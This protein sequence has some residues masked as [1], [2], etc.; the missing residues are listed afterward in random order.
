[1]IHLDQSR[2]ARRLADEEVYLARRLG[3][4]RALGIALRAAGL[5]RGGP[6]GVALLEEA[7]TVLARSSARLEQ[8]RALADYGAA[9]RRANRRTESREP[10]RRALDLAVQCGAAPLADRA[11]Q[12]LAAAGV[13]PRR[14][15]SGVDALTPS[16]LRV[17]RMAAD[18]M[19]NRAIAKA[20][21]VTIKTVEVHLS[22]AYR[23]LDIASRTALAAALN[24]R[25]TGE[26]DM[27]D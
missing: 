10:L 15:A 6:A 24:H 22:S 14:A 21:F 17:V 26:R 1:L 20:L 7:A 23:K 5:V 9:L 13:R 2:E 12:D 27:T 11:R 8:A 16:E 4:P 25:A 18:G 19:G 3:V